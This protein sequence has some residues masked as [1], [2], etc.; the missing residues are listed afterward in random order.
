MDWYTKQN[1]KI[2]GGQTNRPKD[3]LLDWP[4][5][6]QTCKW[7]TDRRT[8]RLTECQIDKLEN[9][10]TDKPSD[11]HTNKTTPWLTKWQID[12]L[13]FHTGRPM[14]WKPDWST[15]LNRHIHISDFINWQ[16]WLNG[17]WELLDSIIDN[18]V[19]DRLRLFS[20]FLQVV[21]LAKLYTKEQNKNTAINKFKKVLQNR[22]QWFNS[23]PFPSSE[24]GEDAFVKCHDT[25]SAQVHCPERWKALQSWIK[26]TY[27]VR[28]VTVYLPFDGLRRVY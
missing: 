27:R 19:P 7:S 11:R 17:Q 21:I 9:S 8:Q 12:S 10:K 15:M 5:D 3:W 16:H 26:N 6:R 13:K 23:Q 20:F 28:T 22:D 4:T 1:D 25:A 18:S 2:I 14:N 24:S